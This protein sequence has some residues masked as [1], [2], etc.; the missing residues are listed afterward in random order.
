MADYLYYMEIRD[1]KLIPAIETDYGMRMHNTYDKIEEILYRFDEL[2]KMKTNLT[3]VD[4]T[5]KSK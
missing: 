1:G 3:S 5:K 2:E 4:E